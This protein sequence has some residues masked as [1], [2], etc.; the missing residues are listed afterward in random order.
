[1]QDPKPG[2]P[3]DLPGVETRTSGLRGQTRL[4]IFGAVIVV[5]ALIGVLHPADKPLQPGESVFRKSDAGG[6]TF[7]NAKLT[8]PLPAG[9]SLADKQ[10]SDEILLHNEDDSCRVLLMRESL[11]VTPESFQQGM[12]KKMTEDGSRITP[13]PH[14]EL[15]GRHAAHMQAL[16]SSGSSE[17]IYTM[18]AGSSIYTLVLV[19]TRTCKTDLGPT[20]QGFRIAS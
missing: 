15:S 12:A 4:L 2:G 7:T 20:A 19:Q 6:L 11:D 8:F 16:L 10:K 14:M 1:M 5:V 18:H 13:Q 9:W 17:D 3:L